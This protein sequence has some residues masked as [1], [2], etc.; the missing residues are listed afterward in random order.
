MNWWPYDL[1]GDLAY[2][3]LSVR[4]VYG[5]SPA[6]EIGPTARL[7]GLIALTWSFTSE[8]AKRIELS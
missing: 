6:G 3:A 7:T 2:I 1:L 8:R 4:H 5:T